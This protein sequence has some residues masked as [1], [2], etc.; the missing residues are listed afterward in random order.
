MRQ[1]KRRRLLSGVAQVGAIAAVLIVAGTTAAFA[2]GTQEG[3]AATTEGPLP[4]RYVVPDSPQPELD[5]VEQAV[6]EAMQADGLD[7]TLEVTHIERTVLEDRLNVMFATGEAFELLHIMENRRPSTVFINAG[8]LRPIDDLI[9]RYFTDSYDRFTED[10]WNAGKVNGVQYTVPAAWKAQT[11]TG[12]EAGWIGA[13]ADKIAQY[14][15]DSFPETR[16]ELFDMLADI[17][18]QTGNSRAYF[19]QGAPQAAQVWL[20]RTH[21]SYPFYVDYGSELFKVTEDGVA[22]SW[23]ESDEFAENARFMRRLYEA[24]LIHP[25]WITLP[26]GTEDSLQQ[27]ALL[28]GFGTTE[29]PEAPADQELGFFLNPERGVYVSTPVLNANGVATTSPHPET[30]IQFLNWLYAERENHDLFLHGI[31]GRHYERVGERL[32]E[33][34]TDSTGQPLYSFR[35]W[36]IGY[37]PWRMFDP[38]IH[39]KALEYQTGEVPGTQ[40][41]L[42]AY[43]RFDPSPVEAEYQNVIAEWD[44]SILPI[45]MGNQD[46]DDAF[47]DA[48]DRMKDAGLDEVVASFVE[49]FEAWHAKQ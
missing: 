5:V 19:W 25:D 12:S 3:G 10:E 23:I 45:K 13:R 40:T 35:Y 30:G 28:S 11:R 7:L 39:P 43:F 17:K 37:R 47:D 14:G 49:Q 8:Q 1:S 42:G 15:Y 21:D 31:E 36:Q 22:S 20:N 33:Q 48:L 4:V 34:V 6:S 24:D 9:D 41:L 26:P 44:R 32:R 27:F 46:Y 2:T 18:A 38:G 16:E 29:V